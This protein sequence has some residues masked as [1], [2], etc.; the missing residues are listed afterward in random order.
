MFGFSR[1]KD[2][3]VRTAEQVYVEVIAVFSQL[4]IL[5]ALALMQ[6]EAVST[7]VSASDGNDLVMGAYRTLFLAA[8]LA[9]HRMIRETLDEKAGDEIVNKVLNESSISDIV[10]M[11]RSSVK[12]TSPEPMIEITREAGLIF[13]AA[14]LF[15]RLLRQKQHQRA[16]E[17]WR[18]CAKGSY[19]TLP[20][21]ATGIAGDS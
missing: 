7:G 4:N 17:V 5:R 3:A 19:A 8:G 20:M 13:Q 14:T 6:R 2:S 10:G 11:I 9:R 18:E 16:F 15:D 21:V 1:K 12:F